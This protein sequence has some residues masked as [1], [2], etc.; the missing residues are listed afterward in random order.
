MALWPDVGLA[1]VWRPSGVGADSSRGVTLEFQQTC[2]F[3]RLT[4]AR[5]NRTQ[6]NR[7]FLFVPPSKPPQVLR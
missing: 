7:T 3:D 2:F 6:P 1:A 5:L 4:E